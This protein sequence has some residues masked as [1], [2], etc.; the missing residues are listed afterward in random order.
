[1]KV[2]VVLEKRIRKKESLGMLVG[3]TTLVTENTTAWYSKT[4]AIES[5]VGPIR[6]QPPDPKRMV[7]SHGP[8]KGEVINIAR[9][10]GRL[11]L[12]EEKKGPGIN[13]TV[14]RVYKDPPY[15]NED[16]YQT[17]V[18]VVAKF[19]IMELEVQGNVL[20]ELAATLE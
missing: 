6:G 9:G 19:A 7:I 15:K 20:D 13:C 8:R 10:L 17:Y 2:W 18:E 16:D 4:E 5:V 3:W 12:R 1:M 11:E 14:R